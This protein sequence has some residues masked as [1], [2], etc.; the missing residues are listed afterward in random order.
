MI[1]D[2]IETHIHGGY[3]IDFNKA[4]KD[5]IHFFA[6]NIKKEGVIAFCPTL[7]TDG[8]ENL[9]K[10]I[11]II[12][13]AK[14]NQTHD[15]AKIIGIH[16]EGCFLNVQ[17]KGIHNEADFMELKPENFKKL[18][19]G[20]IIKIVTLAPELDMGLIK[21]LK[22]K[23]IIVHAG[24]TTADNIYG[25]D[26]TTH[27]FNAMP[28]PNVE[29]FEN[30]ITYKAMINGDIYSEIIADFIHNDED[31]LKLFFETK[32]KDKIILVSDA[33]PIAHSGKEKIIF[34]DKEIFKNGRDKKGTLGGS[35]NFL[36]DIVKK[37][38][39]SRLLKEDEVQ[40]MVHDNPIK[41]LNLKEEDLL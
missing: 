27:H 22:D 11:S 40:K 12:R 20:D 39:N 41:H 34:C 16:L 35:I 13:C 19:G 26:G 1:S 36:S 10:Q 4:G 23:G 24:H 37:L 3:G 38:I 28:K 15:E 21:Y 33:L 6:K 25:V 7:A 29:D 18:E 31:T 32:P 2:I 9:K 8:F 5:D 30:T 17:K 14:N